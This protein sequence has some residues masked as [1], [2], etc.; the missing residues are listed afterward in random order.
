MARCSLSDEYEYGHVFGIVT[1]SH[2]R[3]QGATYLQVQEKLG[4]KTSHYQEIDN[5]TIAASK[6]GKSNAKKESMPGGITTLAFRSPRCFAHDIRIDALQHTCLP[7][8]Q[9]EG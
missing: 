4:V 3:A 7:G 6:F 2:V 8:E 9:L 1:T 5:Y